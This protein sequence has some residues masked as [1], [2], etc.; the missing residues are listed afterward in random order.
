MAIYIGV[1]GAVKEVVG[2]YI[3][4]NGQVLPIYT[5]NKLPSGYLAVSHVY[6]TYNGSN[7][8][9]IE[10]QNIKPGVYTKIIYIGAPSS[11]NS[12]HSGNVYWF[13]CVRFYAGEGH[14]YSNNIHTFTPTGYV[15]EGY[16]SGSNKMVLHS[17]VNT[18]PNKNNLSILTLNKNTNKESYHKINGTNEKLFSNTSSSL[19]DGTN[20]IKLLYSGFHICCYCV[21]Y[22]NILNSNTPAGEFYPALR[23][24]DGAAGLYDTVT[25]TFFTNS[26]IAAGPVINDYNLPDVS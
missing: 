2:G 23:K 17:D 1:G 6:N 25:K 14:S 20:D 8:G 16:G 5:G 15:G 19:P 12:Y 7:T 22:L 11:H 9:S 26:Y 10:L 13:D 24:S 18:T 4:H 3:G 21:I